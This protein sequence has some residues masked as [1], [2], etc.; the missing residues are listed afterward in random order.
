MARYAISDIHGCSKTFETLLRKISFSKNDTLYLL[1]DYID[2]G[3]DSKGVIDYIWHLQ[4]KGFQVH[5]LM[6]NHEDMLLENLREGYHDGESETLASFEVEHS[7]DIPK[8]YLDWIKNLPYYFEL[9]KYIMVH[10]GLNFTIENPLEDNYA[11]LWARHWY[12][13]VNKDWLSGRIIVHGHTPI[14]DYAIKESIQFLEDLPIID[15]DAGCAIRGS[16]YG[17][18]CALNL[19]SREVIFQKNVE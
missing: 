8:P 6:G 12:N 7:L 15:I 1:G 4:K 3:P 13:E 10:A 16:G 11:M 2:K 17:H 19:D 14:K 5:C 18:L 9:D